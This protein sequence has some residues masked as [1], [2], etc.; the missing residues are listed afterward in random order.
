MIPIS[1]LSSRWI[2][3]RPADEADSIS[4]SAAN[5]DTASLD[6]ASLDPASLDPASLWGSGIGG[7]GNRISAESRYDLLGINS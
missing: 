1:V 7:L 4:F 5:L 3:F 6:T 2:L